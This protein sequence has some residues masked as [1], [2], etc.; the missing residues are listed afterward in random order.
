MNFD[1]ESVFF[2]QT[3]ERTLFY[4]PKIEIKPVH[5]A[6]GLFRAICSKYAEAQDQ[7]TAIYP[8]AH[9]NS[10]VDEQ[11]RGV[12]NSILSADGALFA[13]AQMSSYTLSH[14][15]HITN[16]NHDRR[17]GEWLF[18]ILTHDNGEGQSPALELLDRLLNQD[19]RQRSDEISTLTL[20]L[21]KSNFELKDARL[22]MPDQHPSSLSIDEA[23][24]FCDP[25]LYSIR[26]GFDCIAKHDKVKGNFGEKLDTLRRLVIWGCFSIYL[27]LTNSGSPDREKRVPMMLSMVESPSPTLRQAST[28]SYL[29][30]ERSIDK[31]FRTAIHDTLNRIAEEGTYG[32]WETDA[33]IRQHIQTMTWKPSSGRMQQ[34]EAR[35]AKYTPQCLLFYESYLSDT[36]NQSPR[37]AFTNAAADMIDQIVSSS[38]TAVAHSLGTRIGL[39]SSGPSS[40]K[41][42]TAVPDLLEVLVR[43][44][45]PPQ[46]QWTIDELARYWAKHYGLLF[47]ALGD[48]NI[49]L[50]EWGINVID[51][52]SLLDNTEALATILELSGYARRYADGVVLVSV[53]K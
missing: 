4:S 34:T 49:R 28:Q 48:E 20:P 47:G 2:D 50:A 29:W 40:R 27:H 5:L 51:G 12:L 38:P 11:I 45:I 9:P 16:D 52:S 44:T 15:S 31:F 39:L 36:A 32:S 21:T 1:F 25:L 18:T 33:D 30:V 3:V 26:K 35:L 42:Y 43:A 7:H 6:N 22:Q 37:D 13:R 17:T 23:G 8:K 10:S 53:R 19:N 46:E 41:R 14:V 24:N